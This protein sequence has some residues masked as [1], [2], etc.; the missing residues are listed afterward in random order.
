MA[1]ELDSLSALF[2]AHEATLAPE[3]NWNLPGW[4]SEFPA[5]VFYC[6]VHSLSIRFQI[7]SRLRLLDSFFVSAPLVE[8]CIRLG[9]LHF[10]VH[11]TP[12]PQVPPKG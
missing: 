11:Q 9:R 8:G 10:S 2:M 7:H 5:C 3:A 6:R 4:S 12:T 1:E